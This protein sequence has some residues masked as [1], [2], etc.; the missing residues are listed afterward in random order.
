MCLALGDNIFYGQ[1]FPALP[2]NARNQSEGDGGASLFGYYVKEPERFGVIEFDDEQKVVS[3][4]EKPQDPKSNYAVT[5]LYFY[6][7][8]LLSMQRALSLQIVVSWK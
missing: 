1:G 2:A 4:Q 3:L 7:N 5:G 6:D 8:K